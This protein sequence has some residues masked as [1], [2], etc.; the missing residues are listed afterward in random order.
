MQHMI[1]QIIMTDLK[2]IVFE[3]AKNFKELMFKKLKDSNK[4]RSTM[5]DPHKWIVASYPVHRSVFALAM[6]KDFLNSEKKYAN[7]HAYQF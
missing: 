3:C 2:E 1:K 6:G 7:E 4:S 5:S